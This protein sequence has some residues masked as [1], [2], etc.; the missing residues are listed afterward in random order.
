MAL[1]PT[2][3]KY[4]PHPLDTPEQAAVR[5]AAKAAWIAERQAEI[6]AGK[7]PQTF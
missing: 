7:P 1:P 6:D 4:E 5:A 2:P 3:R